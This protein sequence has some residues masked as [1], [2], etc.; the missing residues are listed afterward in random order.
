MNYEKEQ[1]TEQKE[2]N[3]WLILNTVFT[4]LNGIAATI[5]AIIALNK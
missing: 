5:L 4:I 1:L 2:T 3:F